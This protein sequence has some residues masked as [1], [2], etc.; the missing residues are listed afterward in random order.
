MRGGRRAQ[1][2]ASS[3]RRAVPRRCQAHARRKGGA[4]WRG[5]WG[6]R[7]R[8]RRSYARHQRTSAAVSALFHVAARCR[9]RFHAVRRA[10]SS[11]SSAGASP[12]R[13][14]TTVP[15]TSALASAMPSGASATART[16]T[17]W[18]RKRAPAGAAA[19]PARGPPGAGGAPRSH[20]RQLPSGHPAASSGI[21]VGWPSGAASAGRAACGGC[22]AAA[23]RAAA[24]S[25]ASAITRRPTPLAAHHSRCVPSAADVSTASPPQKAALSSGVEAA[26]P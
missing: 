23:R 3:L 21:A 2:A 8:Q 10:H 12:A 1:T 20:T 5:H 4:Q 26:W 18:S 19:K 22:G 13:R 11:A 6:G 17:E 7:A 16:A 24:A 14:A 15:Q 9:I 25:A